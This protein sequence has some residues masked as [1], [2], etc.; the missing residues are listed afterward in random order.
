MPAFCSKQPA[1]THKKQQ[2]TSTLPN[3][4]NSISPNY[5]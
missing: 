1:V 4:Q 3:N 5:L 2:A